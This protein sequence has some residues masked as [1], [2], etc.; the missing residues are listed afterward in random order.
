ML[1]IHFSTGTAWTKI[2]EVEGQLHNDLLVLIEE[3]VMEH[4]EEFIKYDYNELLEE[5][6]DEEIN[7]LYL[8][9]NGGEYYINTI[10]NIEVE[11]V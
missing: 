9:I 6:T 7:E 8:P 1:R 10:V 5:H 3:Y 4:E 2:I 11:E